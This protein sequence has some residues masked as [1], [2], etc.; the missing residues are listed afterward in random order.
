MALQVAPAEAAASHPHGFA[1][2]VDSQVRQEELKTFLP[3][4]ITFHLCQFEA[5]M[6][7]QV[8]DGY[9]IMKRWTI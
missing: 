1:L 2:K 6:T 9:L 4:S 7:E 5:G 3:L 8:C